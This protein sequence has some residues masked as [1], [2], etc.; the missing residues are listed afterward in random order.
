MS[1]ARELE[2]LGATVIGETVLTPEQQKELQKPLE[3]RAVRERSQSGRTF[4]YIEGY[5]TIDTANRIFGYDGWSMEVKSIDK[6]V[7]AEKN[8]VY[9]ATVGVH[10][11]TAYRE[12]VGHGIS[13]GASNEAQETAIKGAVTDAMKRAFRTFGSQFGN[14]LY[15][16]D[17]PELAD[18]PPQGRVDA[19]FEWASG[20]YGLDEARVFEILGV[21]SRSAVGNLPA[22]VAKIESSQK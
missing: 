7:D 14:S 10:V 6:I 18:T 20:T 17:G 2:I 13:A 12:D 22:S 15:D 11:G 19:F 16:K 1:V 9:Q 8:S 5:Y 3:R 4:S 21:E